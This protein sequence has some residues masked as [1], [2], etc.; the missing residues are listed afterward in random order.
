MKKCCD[1]HHE[2]R[3]CCT[4]IPGPQDMDGREEHHDPF[5]SHEIEGHREVSK[6]LYTL[7]SKAPLLAKKAP[8]FAILGY[9]FEKETKKN[10]EPNFWDHI[11]AITRSPEFGF[12]WKFDR[13][14]R[15]GLPQLPTYLRD[16]NSPQ[17]PYAH[18]EVLVTLVLVNLLSYFGHN[19]A[20]WRYEAR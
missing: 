14:N 15:D 2:K 9:F 20:T 5:W 7:G 13:M 19:S 18:I 12:D 11:L 3:V 17:K 8:L 1:K 6:K 16:V 4:A 10:R